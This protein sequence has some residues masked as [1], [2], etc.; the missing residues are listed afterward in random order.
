[1][2]AYLESDLLET[3]REAMIYVERTLPNGQVRHGLVGAIDLEEYSYE[4]DKEARIR[5]TEGWVAS[6]IPPRVHIRENAPMELPHVLLLVDDERK[7]VIEPLEKAALPLL[8]ECTLMQGGGSIRG[9]L[10]GKEQ[11]DRILAALGTLGQ[12]RSMLFAVGD[13]NHSLVTAKTC[14]QNHPN[15]LF[16]G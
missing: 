14:Y 7:T 12:D 2:A 8:Y 16:A 4:R 15:P 1:M 13:G 11:Q 9:Y 6:R 10:V 5:A 3:Y